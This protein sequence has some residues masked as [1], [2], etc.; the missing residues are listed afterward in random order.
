M[1]IIGLILFFGCF[2]L[3]AYFTWTE[4]VEAIKS[5]VP[6]AKFLLKNKHGNP[7]LDDTDYCYVVE[8]KNGW[9]RYKLGKNGAPILTAKIGDFI[10]N[11][12]FVENT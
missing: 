5:V 1:L 4:R 2:A 8:V 6:G 10:A 9:V 7:F 3:L 12:E 11:K